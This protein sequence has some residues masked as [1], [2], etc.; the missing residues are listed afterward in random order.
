MVDKKEESA[1]A[2]ITRI[3]SF[4]QLYLCYHKNKLLR[5]PAASHIIGWS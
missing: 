2:L 1:P 5:A 3:A 4:P